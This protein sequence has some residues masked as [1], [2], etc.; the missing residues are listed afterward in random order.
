MCA[1]WVLSIISKW[2][3]VALWY[4]RMARLN[5][6]SQNSLPCIFWLGLAT[7]ETVERFW[8]WKWI[9]NQLAAQ[10]I[11]GLISWWAAPAPSSPGSSFSLSDS[12]AGCVFGPMTKDGHPL[13]TTKGRGNT[14]R[15]WYHSVFPVGHSSYLGFHF[16]HAL[17]TSPSSS[18]PNGLPSGLQAD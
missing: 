7:R 14:N 16:V 12:W 13:H 4:A 18:P 2:A 17:L 9:S 1:I 3:V 6:I 5:Y 10:I 11:G 8:G 15:H